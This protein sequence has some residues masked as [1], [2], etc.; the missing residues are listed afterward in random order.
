[1]TLWEEATGAALMAF[2]TWE[3]AEGQ[4]G[5]EQLVLASQR[6]EAAN[7]VT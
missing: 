4:G 2:L 6:E 7:A 3:R 1:M 5:E